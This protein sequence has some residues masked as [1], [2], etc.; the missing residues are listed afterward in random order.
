LPAVFLAGFSWPPEAVPAWLRRGALLLPSTPGMAGFLRLDQMGATLSEV[1]GEWMTLWVL[2]IVYFL[3]A[4]LVAAH[5]RTARPAGP[6]SRASEAA[7]G[8]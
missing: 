7:P 4:W 1:R 3:L 6:E 8:R 2:A 5:P